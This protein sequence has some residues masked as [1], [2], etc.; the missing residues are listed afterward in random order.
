VGQA[1]NVYIFPGLGLGAIVS[2]ATRITDSMALAAAR[3]LAAAVTSERFASGALYP[4][5]SSLREVSRSISLAVAREAIES[6]LARSS[7][8]T[9]EADV[10]AAMWWPEYVPYLPA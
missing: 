2:E 7:A 10:D 1:N 8:D 3:T 6:G 9:L 4:P 5:I